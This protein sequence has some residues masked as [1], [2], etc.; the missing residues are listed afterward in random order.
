MLLLRLRHR[1]LLLRSRSPNE[2][3]GG[4]SSLAK[5]YP[6]LAEKLEK[7]KPKVET[8]KVKGKVKSSRTMN[9]LQTK[10]A[11]NKIKDK[12]RRNQ[13]SNAS[14]QSQSPSYGLANSPGYHVSTS[15]PSLSMASPAPSPS[16]ASPDIVQAQLGL[17]CHSEQTTATL[18]MSFSLNNS[19]PDMTSTSATQ[20]LPGLSQIN[21][22]NSLNFQTFMNLAKLGLPVP[23]QSDI[24][25]TLKQLA[26]A[27]NF[28]VDGAM[29]TTDSG[30]G[31][32]PPIALAGL[33]T[34]TIVPPADILGVLPMFNPQS[35]PPPPYSSVHHKPTI[36]I[37]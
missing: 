13:G 22:L 29:L 1:Q 2:G 3:T 5:I 18:P 14:S 36:P 15:S 35:G 20:S 9:S 19:A 21:M 28:P 37:P 33:P 34:G 17:S 32:P 30:S 10:I 27:A 23:T 11:Q 16:V 26:K 7:I 8:A 24:E 31:L 4:H 25:Q 6:E 12:I